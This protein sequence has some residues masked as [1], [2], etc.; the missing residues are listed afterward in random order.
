[1][2]PSSRRSFLALGLGAAAGL[3]GWEWLTTRREADGLPYP[4]RRA[5]E[6]NERLGGRWFT[7]SR[8]APTLRPEMAREPRVNCEEGLRSEFDLSAWQFGGPGTP[9]LKD[10]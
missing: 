3:V 7:P 4:L 6:F 5:L 8:L 9:A 10:S 1:M 2:R